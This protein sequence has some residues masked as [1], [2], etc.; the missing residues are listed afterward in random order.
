MRLERMSVPGIVYFI[1]KAAPSSIAAHESRPVDGVSNP[2]G[3]R[4]V[5]ARPG[6]NGSAKRPSRHTASITS[7]FTADIRVAEYA[8]GRCR[9]SESLA[10]T[11]FIRIFGGS[12][13]TGISFVCYSRARQLVLLHTLFVI[14]L[15][16]PR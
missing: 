10:R 8:C 5:T 3:V 2:E 15:E 12:H 14:V 11:C 13:V 1:P 16:R 4:L 9:G 6:E 7:G